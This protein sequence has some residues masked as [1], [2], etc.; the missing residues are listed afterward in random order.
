MTQRKN[1]I[2]L[3]APT[4]LWLAVFFVIPS[5]AM[6]LVS[7]RPANADGGIE[8]GWTLDAWRALGDPDYPIILWRTVWLSV[9]T[10][11]VCLAIALPIAFL[12]GKLEGKWRGILLMLVIVPFWTNF[13][14][15][16]AAWRIILHPEGM[17]R[18]V[19][20]NV[21]LIE[22]DTLLLYNE[23]AVLMVMIYTH[24]PFAILPLY[25]AAERFDYSLLEAARDLGAS[26]FRAVMRVFVPGVSRGLLTAMALVLIP[27]LGSYVI[28]DLVG[29]P[30]DEMIGNKI[31]QR[32]LGNRN[33]PQAATLSLALLVIT[34]I[35]ILVVFLIN[36]KEQADSR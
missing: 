35:P 23:G 9:V 24:L 17:I 10:T 31:A 20:L 3:T 14:I 5:F 6:F 34:L 12:L 29:G 2:L 26:G 15:R 27:A 21:G 8:P 16:V 4:L 30:S 7:F 25:A 28:P 18:Q 11:A 33:L 19:L 36:R 22:P 1:E 13:V 32:T